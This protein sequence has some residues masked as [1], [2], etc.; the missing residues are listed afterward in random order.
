MEPIERMQRFPAYLALMLASVSANAQSPGNDDLAALAA[1]ADLVALAQVVDTD[2]QYTREFPSGGTAFL[3]VLI[4]Y[5]VTRPYGDLIQVYEEGL[6]DNECYFPDPPAGEEGR[7]Y[8]VFLRISPERPAQFN[9]LDNGCA[10][11]AL[12]T[13]D[14]GYALRWPTDGIRSAAVPADLALPLK[15]ADRDAIVDD[16][17]LT[18]EHR[19]D[20]RSAGWLRE[21]EDGRFTFTRGIPLDQVRSLI[22]E[23]NLTLDRSLLRPET[24]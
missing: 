14:N 7:R 3:R 1:R 11:A 5:K 19:N 18:V 2:Y 24:D 22:G 20:W 8:L 10:L 23:E 9:G 16:A 13:A 21:L 6:H 17:S 15:F 4:P 12:V